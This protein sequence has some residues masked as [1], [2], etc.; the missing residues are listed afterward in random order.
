MAYRYGNRQQITLL[1]DSIEDYVTAD[2]PVRAYDIFIEAMDVDFLGLDLDDK[3]VGNAAYD[4]L[5]MLK[6]LIYS[7]SYGWRSSRKIERALHHNLSFIWL[8][9]GLKPDHKT[10]SRFRKDH[11]V[12]LKKV[13][14][15]CARICYN[16]GLI[17]GNTLFV[18]GS[19][20]R[21]NASAKQTHSKQ[22]WQKIADRVDQRIQQLFETCERNDN[23]ESE[24]LVKMDKELQGQ[25]RLKTK[26]AHLLEEFKDEEKI[27]GTDSDSRIMH[28]RQGSHS[29]YNGQI[30]V[31]E[32]HGLIVSSDVTSEPNDLNHVAHRQITQAEDTLDQ[33]C[34]TA[35]GDGGYS[36]VDDLKKLADEGRT[37]VVPTAG[38]VVKERDNPFGKHAFCYDEKGDRYICPAGKGMYRSHNKKGTNK[39]VYRMLDASA[40]RLCR[41]YGSCTQAKRGRTIIRLRNEKTKNHLDKI[42]TSA[43]GQAIYAKRK[44]KAELPFGYFKRNLAAGQFLLRG[45]EGVKAELALLSCSFNISRMLTLLGGVGPMCESIQVIGSIKG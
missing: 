30:V 26:I 38:Q 33:R 41:H 27:N 15:Q 6:I 32:Q 10:L 14:Q 36:S 2:D 43:E 19:K 9:G 45:F 8:A 25:T 37:V 7:Y 4:P 31:D 23:L 42:H 28:G 17:E 1:P 44:L 40:C 18:D 35:C 22:G 24:D 34:A 20:F 39:I 13:L 21:A 11:L 12:L 3:A 16:L 29:S 5:T